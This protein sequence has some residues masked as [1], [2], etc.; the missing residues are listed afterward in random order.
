[1]HV[2]IAFADH[3]EAVPL[4][5]AVRGAIAKSRDEQ[6]APLGI[7]RRDHRRQHVTADASPL[8]SGIDVE[9]LERRTVGNPLDRNESDATTIDADMPGEAGI[10]AGTKPFPRTFGVEPTNPL[11]ARAHRRQP[12]RQE[13]L[14]VR[15]DRILE[16]DH[17]RHAIANRPP[18]RLLDW[19]PAGQLDD[20]GASWGL[21]ATCLVAGRARARA[22][23]AIHHVHGFADGRRCRFH[24][25]FAQRRVRMNRERQIL[26]RS[27]GLEG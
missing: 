16:G 26:G 17:A 18:S 7:S 24:Q 25:R 2:P 9:V 21:R 10:E 12:Q 27:D 13:L 4:I 11:Q 3:D 22:S 5:E 20:G 6:R 1:M 23:S 8:R 15:V 19:T 14:E